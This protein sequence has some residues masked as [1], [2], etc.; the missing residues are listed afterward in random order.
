[1]KDNIE[2]ELLA[3]LLGK[4]DALFEPVNPFR[5]PAGDQGRWQRR[6][7][8]L[9]RPGWLG[10]GLL[11]WSNPGEDGAEKKR[12]SRAMAA[13]KDQ[14]LVRMEGKSMGLTAEGLVAARKL[15]GNIQLEA[16]LPGLDFFLRLLG[17]DA[18]WM[19]EGGKGIITRGYI[20]ECS[21]AG[22]GPMPKGTIGKPRLPD[23][24]G[25]VAYAMIPLTV[26]DLIDHDYQPDFE[27][28]LYHLTASGKALAE[29]RRDKGKADP[30]AWL[31]LAS[32][33]IKAPDA[34]AENAY[35]IAWE[36]TITELKYA[37]PLQVNCIKHNL[38]ACTWPNTVLPKRDRYKHGRKRTSKHA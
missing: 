4:V 38:S 37:K 9:G 8:Y 17:T 35:Y 23:S 28:P 12:I 32:L 6:Y 10:P 2:S 16:C 18:E 14:G 33:V 11:P 22:Y 20:S 27:L 13:L 30:D 21:M 1:M 31:K 26:A 34:K 19:L 25:W 36:Q 29:E 3:A 7:K 15:V 24:A 5:E